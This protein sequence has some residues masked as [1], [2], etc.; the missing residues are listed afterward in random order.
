[1]VEFYP[2]L[3][4]LQILFIHLPFLLSP[5][6][7]LIHSILQLQGTLVSH[8][9]TATWDRDFIITTLDLKGS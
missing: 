6:Y 7:Q 4:F 5:A 3:L 8:F 1:M 9:V 2:F